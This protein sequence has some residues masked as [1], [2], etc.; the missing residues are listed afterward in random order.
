[1]EGGKFE[2]NSLENNYL[3]YQL[4]ATILVLHKSLIVENQAEWHESRSPVDLALLIFKMLKKNGRW[5][6][7]QG[8]NTFRKMKKLLSLIMRWNDIAIENC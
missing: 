2:E 1:M 5:L 6:E 8:L 3:C 7:G 4:R